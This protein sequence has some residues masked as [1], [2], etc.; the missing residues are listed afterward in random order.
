MTSPEPKL[1]VAFNWVI[2]MASSFTGPDEWFL[3]MD[4]AT[5][6]LLRILE[7][8]PR[9][10]ANLSLGGWVSRWIR[11]N[12]PEVAEMI[13]QGVKEGRYEI[14]NRPYFHATM[15][16]LA[17]DEAADQV[18]RSVEIN[19]EVWGVHPVG[20][21]HNGWPWDPVTG[22]ALLDNGI[23]YQLLANWQLYH[24]TDPP[25]ADHAATY[26]AARVHTVGE[27]QIPALWVSFSKGDI[28]VP[29][30]MCPAYFLQVLQGK[31]PMRQFQQGVERIQAMNQQGDMLALFFSDSETFWREPYTGASGLSQAE[32]EARYDEMLSYLESLPYVEFT[33]CK[34]YVAA[35]PPRST[36][37][38]RPSVSPFGPGQGFDTWVDG[39]FKQ[40]YNLNIQC[41]R[42]TEDIHTAESILRFARKLGADVSKAE[43]QLEEAWQHLMLSKTAV[44]R[45]LAPK[46]AITLWCD[47][48]AISA[49]RLAREAIDLIEIAGVVGNREREEKAE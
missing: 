39:A 5:K 17:Y 14:V 36:Y 7:R 32:M 30:E 15:S 47:E 43:A 35:F 40:A 10:R 23:Q 8:H 19:Q 45:G 41:A 27:S 26:R 31:K 11:D 38:L 18:R 16:M 21:H 22:K 3:T 20:A 9:V 33:L 2:Y 48:H 1:H 28:G 42:A 29:Q 49:S 37:Y 46:E 34:D 4:N 12:R 24:Y 6:P 44:G 25:V 13:R